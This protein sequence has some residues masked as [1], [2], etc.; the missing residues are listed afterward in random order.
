MFFIAK[1]RVT[2]LLKGGQVISLMKELLS[3]E[4]I[5]LVEEH[6]EIVE[7]PSN[8][9]ICISILFIKLILMLSDE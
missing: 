5:M 3:V 2:S 1:F 9:Y 8:Y 4:W 6:C 7:V